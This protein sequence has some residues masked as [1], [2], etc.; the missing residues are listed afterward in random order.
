[1]TNAPAMTLTL[2]ANALDALVR[3]RQALSAFQAVGHGSD[4]GGDLYLAS[5]AA[6]EELGKQVATLAQAAESS[7][8]NQ[9]HIVQ[10]SPAQNMRHRYARG[11]VTNQ[12]KQKLLSRLKQDQGDDLLAEDII[13]LIAVARNDQDSFS[14]ASRELDRLIGLDTPA[15]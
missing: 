4:E 6:A 9:S 2:D 5:E 7:R 8:A 13:E 14:A 1:M 15:A 11:P 12:L 3:Y 10:D